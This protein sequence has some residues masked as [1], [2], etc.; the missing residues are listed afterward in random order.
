VGILPSVSGPS[1]SV[2]P[3]VDP[4]TVEAPVD[5]ELA[6]VTIPKKL[7]TVESSA[8]PAGSVCI[9]QTN[10]YRY[11]WRVG[12]RGHE[13]SLPGGAKGADPARGGAFRIE[14]PAPRSRTHWAN[15]CSVPSKTSG[16][17]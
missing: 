15:R 13:S 12:R 11:F 8:D 5:P 17:R 14:A 10:W 3:R 6:P 9:R 4:D 1:L 7:K 16:T 2:L